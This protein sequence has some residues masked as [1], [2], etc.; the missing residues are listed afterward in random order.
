M[1][2][3]EEMEVRFLA[4]MG[5]RKGRGGEG[6][7]EGGKVRGREGRKLVSREGGKRG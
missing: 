3:N 6:G 4:V 2:K 1:G 5:G 7:M